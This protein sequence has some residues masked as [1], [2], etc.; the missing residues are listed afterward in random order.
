VDSGQVVA[1]LYYKAHGWRLLNQALA[2]I[3]HRPSPSAEKQRVLDFV[4][5]LGRKRGLAVVSDLP[6][7]GWRYLKGNQLTA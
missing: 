5:Q 2:D 1:K 4:D 3:M 7:L 6:T